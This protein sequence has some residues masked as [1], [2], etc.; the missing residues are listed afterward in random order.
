MAQENSSS[1]V[2]IDFEKALHERYLAYAVS[3]IMSRSLPDVRDGLKPVHRRLIYAMQQLRLNPEAGFKKCARVVGDVMGKYHPHGDAAI[4][5][6]L[7]RL[8]QDFSVRYPLIEGQGNFGNIDGDD[9]AAMRYTEA[10]LSKIAMLLMEGLEENAV[11]FR[12]TYDGEGEEPL[13]FPA[14]FPNLLAN[15]ATGIAVGMATSI[16]PHNV[17]EICQALIMLIDQPHVTIEQLL[18]VLPGPDFPTGGVL[19]ENTEVILKAY[20]T[21]RGNF[22]LRA[23]WEREDLKGGNYK[24]IIKEIPYQ[25]EKSKLIEKIALLLNDKKLPFLE[26]ITDESADDVRI[27]LYPKNRNIDENLLMQSLFK[28][29]ELEIRISLNM[30]A[31]DSHNVPKVMSLKEVLQAFLDHRFHVQKRRTHFRLEHIKDRLEVLSGFLIAYLNLDTVIK[32]IRDE[33]DA[34]TALME[35]FN[36]NENQVESI[37]NIRLRCLR[38][39]QEIEIRQEFEALQ[40]EQKTLENLMESIKLQWKNIRQQIE[41]LRKAF[42]NQTVLGQRKT[43]LSPPSDFIISPLIQVIEPEDITIICSAKNWVRC[44][45]GHNPTAPI[46]YKEGDN[47]RFMFQA[48]STDKLV[49]FATNGRF[50]TL[51]IDKIPKTKGPGDPI[52]FLID[53][54]NTHEIIHA[55]IVSSHNSKQEFLVSSSEGRGFIIKVQDT[56]A[57]TKLGKQT[58]MVNEKDPAQFC[59]PIQ[60]DNIAIIGENRKL[61]IFSKDEVPH[62][63]KGRG[64]ILQRFKDGKVSD[65]TTFILSKGLQW[66]KQDKTTTL[67]ELMPWLGKRSSG[68]RLAPTGFPQNN[69]FN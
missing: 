40:N 1:V 16:P 48:Q 15:G 67:T 50:Y 20:E 23:R 46:T 5:G 4:Y 35:R 56:L 18:T 34:K 28:L 69:R 31:L 47:E 37:L 43:T 13:V 57:H 24:I 64:V 38:K 12:P 52:R 17:D 54:P 29:S 32:I 63:I 61:L 53:L 58:L 41:K 21:G 7:V 49:L 66:K 10:R 55:F 3:T 36:L 59:V 6:A 8:A 22:R 68:G 45:K 51:G 27:V 26:D 65:I 33:E 2:P 14:A 62:M 30:N 60:G 44:L 9:A 25:V 19:I 39:L 11:D 42:G